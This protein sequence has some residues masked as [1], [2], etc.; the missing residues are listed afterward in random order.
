MRTVE[1]NGTW[2]TVERHLK[3]LIPMTH[4]MLS[5]NLIKENVLMFW[6]INVF[7]S[8]IWVEFVLTQ[9]NWMPYNINKS[10]GSYSFLCII[11]L[12]WGNLHLKKL[13]WDFQI[14]YFFFLSLLVT[15]TMTKFYPFAIWRSICHFSFGWGVGSWNHM[16]LRMN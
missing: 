15:L 12:K 8:M 16:V 9:F 4:P 7:F 6:L 1:K 14:I 13:G 3:Y 5:T 10:I 11:I 2:Q